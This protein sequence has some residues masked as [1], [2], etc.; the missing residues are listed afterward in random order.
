LARFGHFEDVRELARARFPKLVE[1]VSQQ[2][3]EAGMADDISLC[4]PD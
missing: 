4:G 1:Q 3:S 2:N